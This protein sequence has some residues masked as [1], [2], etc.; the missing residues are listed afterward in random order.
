MAENKRLEAS[1]AAGRGTKAWTRARAAPTFFPDTTTA[2]MA[3]TTT[4]T[5]ADESVPVFHDYTLRSDFE[6]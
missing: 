2:N 4:A 5:A 1:A 6:R 3:T